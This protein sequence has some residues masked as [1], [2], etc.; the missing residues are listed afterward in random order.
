M[1][2]IIPEQESLSNLLRP[3]T[4]SAHREREEGDGGKTRR[5][6]LCVSLVV[7]WNCYSDRNKWRQHA[8]SWSFHQRHMCWYYLLTSTRL[9]C[10]DL[11]EGSPR[12]CYRHPTV[13]NRM[14]YIHYV[15]RRIW[16]Q[17]YQLHTYGIIPNSMSHSIYS[18]CHPHVR[19]SLLAPITSLAG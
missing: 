11:K 2:G 7:V 17:L 5:Y 16:L 12:F 15:L 3:W 9:P 10:R 14:G 4:Y 1:I 19:D 6:I 13:G 8:R 18:S